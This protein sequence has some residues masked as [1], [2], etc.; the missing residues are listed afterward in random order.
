[1]TATTPDPHFILPDDQLTGIDALDSITSQEGPRPGFSEPLT[2]NLGTMV[3]ITSGWPSTA[4]ALTYQIQ[5]SGGL[6]EGEWIQKDDA[7]GAAQ[8]FGT[9]DFRLIR[10]PHDPFGGAAN[11]MIGST[12]LYSTV[13]DRLLLIS[14]ETSDDTTYNISYRASGGNPQNWTTTTFTVSRGSS[15]EVSIEGW[16]DRG[17]VLHLLTR[18]TNRDDNIDFDHWASTDGGLTWS[19][20][21]RSLLERSL[22][23]FSL[24]T[25]IRRMRVQR[26]GDYVR[27]LMVDGS[28][29]CTVLLSRN[30]GA[31][32]TSLGDGGIS[33]SLYAKGNTYDEYSIDMVGVGDESGTF[34]I[35][36]FHSQDVVTYYAA[37]GDDHFA[38]T[39]T[40]TGETS[41]KRILLARGP[42]KI[43]AMYSRDD[44]EFTGWK[45]FHQ[46]RNAALD[47]PTQAGIWPATDDIG[48]YFPFAQFMIATGGTLWFWGGIMDDFA[49]AVRQQGS[50]FFGLLDWDRRTIHDTGYSAATTG[51]IWTRYWVSL[52]GHPAQN[53]GPIAESSNNSTLSWA[54]NRTR[55]ADDNST[56][57]YY[58]WNYTDPSTTM[59]WIT[60]GSLFSWIAEAD[61]VGD[62]N[63]DRMAFHVRGGDGTLTFDVSVRMDDSSQVR[64]Y[65]NAATSSLTLIA[66]AGVGAT[67]VEFRLALRKLSS[68]VLADL[69]WKAL[70]GDTWSNTGTLTLATTASAT[71]SIYRWGHIEAGGTERTSFWRV[72]A[73]RQDDNLRQFNF[74]N[75][76]N[77]NGRLLSPS[78]VLVDDSVW[79]GW[80]GGMAFE[81]D[82]WEGH[83]DYDFAAANLFTPQLDS[84]WR[85]TSTNT[86]DIILKADGVHARF[87]HDGCALFNTTTRTS[88]IHY[89]TTSDFATVN[90]AFTMSA[91]VFTSGIDTVFGTA[92]KITDTSAAES[93]DLKGAYL[94]VLTG[95]AAGR[96][97]EIERQISHSG[98]EFILHLASTQ[99]LLSLGMVATDS[100]VVW[101]PQMGATWA[102]QTYQYMRIRLP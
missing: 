12:M 102:G 61:T 45:T 25:G 52:F 10:A 6:Y 89:S 88:Y 16:E 22:G 27:W 73:H 93:Y 31:S 63:S 96:T 94:G 5:H 47:T 48:Y 13:Y 33:S 26:S 43:Y 91:D 41:S 30:R 76:S 95:T 24:P 39:G 97:W 7:D 84:V 9:N 70:S 1:M 51:K 71:Q 65:D 72:A 67:Y 86:Q 66:D 40:L 62:V 8:W 14:K 3:P 21:G 78:P 100:V 17:G 60:D 64:V 87:S 49:G 35:H 15:A 92:V 74:S 79:V 90:A 58:R 20:I 38:S 82:E 83:S 85:S 28:G 2:A 68:D 53:G 19:R 81:G 55:I 42:A 4:Y 34:I 56:G 11:Q 37:S 99:S 57:Q 29:D 75:P 77:L 101:L 36:T 50:A 44:P 98:A 18:F 54:I 59:D 32:W 46:N 69:S 23:K 80:T